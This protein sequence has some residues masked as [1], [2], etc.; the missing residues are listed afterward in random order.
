MYT[1]F[2]AQYYFELIS[3]SF[4]P[5]KDT[6]PHRMPRNIFPPR[7]NLLYFY[8]HMLLYIQQDP[9]KT[10]NINTNM[11]CLPYY[12]QWKP[13]D[14]LFNVSSKQSLLRSF[15]NVQLWIDILKYYQILYGHLALTWTQKL[16]K[17]KAKLRTFY[18]SQLS[19]FHTD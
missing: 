5:E 18:Y 19:I 4:L 13:K 1:I 6:I 8:P 16:W 11:S 7:V 2:Q 10:R 3:K 12:F 14:I 9:Y 17:F 15:W